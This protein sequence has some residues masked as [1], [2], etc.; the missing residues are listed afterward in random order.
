[1]ATRLIQGVAVEIEGS[2]APVVCIHGLGG[3][4]N[5]WTPLAAS[6]SRYRQVRIDLPFSGRS[7]SPGGA[8]DLH[9][10]TASVRALFEALALPRAHLVGHSMGAM[11]CLALAAQAPQLVASLALFAPLPGADESARPGLRARADAAR[12]GGDAALQQIA[13]QAVAGTTAAATRSARPI[14][15][16]FVRESV[17]R[18]SPA[19]YAAMC[20]IL[21]AEPPFSLEQV[22]CPVLL[23]G[24]DEDPI[25]PPAALRAL[26]A[27]LRRPSVRILRECGHWPPVERPHHCAIELGDFWRRLAD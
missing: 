18:Q 24:G 25:A 9:T 23:V 20:D 8:A 17:M 22:A 13:D 14:A 27:R 7:G 16:A 1:M 10:L 2:G 21:A 6:L 11:V 26:A 12:I 15:A 3:S 5:L 19:G 4:S